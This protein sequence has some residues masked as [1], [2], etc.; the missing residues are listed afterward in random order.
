MITLVANC[1]ACVLLGLHR[2][3]APKQEHTDFWKHAATKFKDHPAVLFDLF[4]EPHGTSWEVWRDGGFVS[5]K[6][7][8]ADEDAFLSAE[9]K[10]K[11]APGFQSIGK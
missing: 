3:R 5:E 6:K 8:P 7:K 10:A 11:A 9:E 1:G 4:N 2:F